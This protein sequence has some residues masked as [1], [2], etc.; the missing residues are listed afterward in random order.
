MPDHVSKM[1]TEPN[2]S[3]LSTL[4]QGLESARVFHKQEGW[5]TVR[6]RIPWR[7]KTTAT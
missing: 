3:R 4:G 6:S 2:H 5:G 1:V 7:M